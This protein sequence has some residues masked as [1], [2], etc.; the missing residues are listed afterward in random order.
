M[1]IFFTEYSG[2]CFELNVVHAETEIGKH[3]ELFVEII[4]P[5]R[6]VVMLA[7]ASL[8][9]GSLYIFLKKPECDI[10]VSV[11]FPFFLVFW[12]RKIFRCR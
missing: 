10:S 5:R 9:K 8:K 6:P 7:A 3:G 2:F 1:N 12:F 11:L 4:R